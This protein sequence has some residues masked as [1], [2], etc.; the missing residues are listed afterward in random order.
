MNRVIWKRFQMPAKKD[1]IAGTCF[2]G[3]MSDSQM[4]ST[5]H[6]GVH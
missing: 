6:D 3:E 2:G 5:K 4:I 1:R